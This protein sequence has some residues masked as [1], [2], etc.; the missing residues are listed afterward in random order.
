M[1]WSA[2]VGVMAVAMALTAF[3]QQPPCCFRGAQPAG[4]RLLLAGVTTRV[5]FS[6]GTTDQQA[7]YRAP[8][9]TATVLTCHAE[10][11]R[12]ASSGFCLG[13][14]RHGA[15]STPCLYSL[16][17]TSRPKRVAI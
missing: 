14:R 15:L 16:Q 11:S 6:C 13:E 5:W 7:R 12:G 3:P 1:I 2:A 9:C 10:T 4:E 8:P 17:P